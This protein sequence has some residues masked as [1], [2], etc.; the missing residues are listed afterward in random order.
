MKIRRL[1]IISLLFVIDKTLQFF[2]VSPTWFNNYADD[3]LFI[4]ISL[5]YALAAH[6]YFVSKHFVFSFWQI[7]ATWLI[8]SVLFE[9]IYPQYSLQ[10]TRDYWDILV[11]GLG[12]IFFKIYLNQGATN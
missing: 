2:C 11:Y 1:A 6:Q 5:G 9:G 4:P 10:F 7:T 3:F 12:A 8:F